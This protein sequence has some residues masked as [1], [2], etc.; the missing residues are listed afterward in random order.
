M[1]LNAQI[2]II[3]SGPAGVSA[4]WPLVDAGLDVLMIDGSGV[5]ELPPP[6]EH[7]SLAGWRASDDRLR[8]ELGTRGPLPQLDR[9]PKFATP[10]SRATLAGFDDAA[11]LASEGYF[12]VGSLAAGGLS[13]IWGALATPFT[14]RDLAG[15][16]EV[17]DEMAAAYVRISKRIGISPPAAL[18]PALSAI[19][20]RLD[21]QR[22]RNAPCRLQPA[23]NAVLAQSSGTRSGCNACGL[24]LH[25]CARGSIYHAAQELA[26]LGAHRNF[27]Y[28]PGIRIER[29]SR[30][31][32]GPVLHGI[33]TD[34]PVRLRSG[35]VVL[36][37]GTL[38]TTSLAI[39]HIGLTGH[40]IRLLGNPVG[41]TAFLVPRLIGADLPDRSFGLGQMFYTAQLDEETE[42]VGVLYG[43]DTLPLA[44]VADRLPF[45]RPA[46]MRA[47]RALAP[48]LILA[49][50]YLPGALG[51]NNIT[52]E[53][54]GRGGR[55]TIRAH[56]TDRSDALLRLAFRQ[57]GRTMRQLG[58]LPVPGATQLLEP[59]SD[60]HPAGTLPM[61]GT[62]PAATETD[63]QLRG[64]PGL[65]VVDGACLP[66]LSARHPT[67]TIMAN[68]DRIGR[69]LARTLAAAPAVPA[70]AD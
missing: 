48:A 19:A 27:A 70:T 20:G 23:Q 25:G 57:L 32:G 6:P 63:G 10:L 42:A 13:R 8:A 21:R 16:G 67:L 61:G 7:D 3:G 1:D 22:V 37:A 5:T 45:A 60:A 68:A 43:A 38:M 51:T 41:G 14:D 47:A 30:E 59:G 29:I 65:Y 66:S 49:T 15:W 26:A 39:R 58:A 18:S 36:A 33:G 64:A 56:R 9:S 4:A 46:A 35:S 11:G 50:G 2:I 24:C 40:P 31:T 55:M 53:D 69:R 62:G 54:D 44:S 34:G 17:R 52:V 28:R 12:A